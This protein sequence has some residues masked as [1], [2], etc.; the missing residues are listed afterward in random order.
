[1]FPK[2]GTTISI[3]ETRT[4]RDLVYFRFQ[5]LISFY[6]YGTGS[7]LLI[8]MPTHKHSWKTLQWS[9][10]LLSF[11]WRMES[12]IKDIMNSI[13]G[14]K[15]KNREYNQRIFQSDIENQS[16]ITVGK[17]KKKTITL[18][19]SFLWK[20]MTKGKVPIKLGWRR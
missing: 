5:F 8:K 13:L 14:N 20:G 12:I 4:V 19:K 6:F 16:Q 1:M 2:L 7:E 17:K 18:H 3:Q 10:H 11:P 15:L 9:I